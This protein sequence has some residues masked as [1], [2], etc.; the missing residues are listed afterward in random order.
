M[1]LSFS[2]SSQLPLGTHAILDVSQIADSSDDPNATSNI[3]LDFTQ[4]ISNAE[5]PSLYFMKCSPDATLLIISKASNQVIKPASVLKMRCDIDKKAWLKGIS[6]REL[7]FYDG[8]DADSG[9]ATKIWFDIDETRCLC[10][11]GMRRG[12]GDKVAEVCHCVCT[13]LSLINFLELTLSISRP[14]PY[15]SL[16]PFATVCYMPR[17]YLCSYQLAIRANRV[18]RVSSRWRCLMVCVCVCVCVCV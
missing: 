5:A 17:Q 9:L 8:K 1:T 12:D 10:A 18:P 3:K 16:S 7:M 15:L 11:Q 2:L 13:C 6:D 4:G 14:P